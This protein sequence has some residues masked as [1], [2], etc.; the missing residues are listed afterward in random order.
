MRRLIITFEKAGK[1]GDA[2]IWKRFAF[3]LSK[4]ARQ[5]AEV[6]LNRI[7]RIARDG[8]L[9]A[10]PGKVLGIGT[11]DKK[12]KVAAFRFS[13]SA[14]VKLQRAGIATMTLE[15]LLSDNPSGS[16]VRIVV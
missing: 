15:K 11:A 5:R 8:D 9:V 10:I 16:K 14:L 13:S 2:P 7:N 12:I 4:P 6:N 1:K 3:L